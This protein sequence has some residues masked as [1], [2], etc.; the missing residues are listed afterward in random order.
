MKKIPTI[1]KQTTNL[2]RSPFSNDGYDNHIT[3]IDSIYDTSKKNVMNEID[4]FEEVL[5]DAT[6]NFNPHEISLNVLKKEEEVV[7]DLVGRITKEEDNIDYANFD[8][9]DKIQFKK[10][11]NE[12]NLALNVKDLEIKPAESFDKN[13]RRT[14]FRDKTS[15]SFYDY[16]KVNKTTANLKPKAKVFN[17]TLFLPTQK[18]HKSI[19]RKS[20][21]KEHPFKENSNFYKKSIENSPGLQ[22][23]QNLQKSTARGNKEEH[24]VTSSFELPRKKHDRQNLYK[25]PSSEVVTKRSNQRLKTHEKGRSTLLKFLDNPSKNHNKSVSNQTKNKSPGRNIIK[26]ATTRQNKETQERTMDFKSLRNKTFYNGVL[27]DKIKGQLFDDSS[28][29][30]KGIS[31]FNASSIVPDFSFTKGKKKRKFAKSQDKNNLFRSIRQKLR[32]IQNA[33]S[34]ED[35][36]MLKAATF[37]RP[38]RIRE[39]FKLKTPGKKDSK[40]MDTLKKERL[41]RRKDRLQLKSQQKLKKQVYEI[42]R[43]C[44]RYSVQSQKEYKEMSYQRL[45]EFLKMNEFDTTFGIVKELELSY[46]KPTAFTTGTNGQDLSALKNLYEYKVKEI[47]DNRKEANKIE[48]DY[49]TGVM[50]P[51]RLVAKIE[52]QIAIKKNV[53]TKLKVT[54]M[55]KKNQDKE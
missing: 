10:I 9:K 55:L 48:R 32:R 51:A 50:D 22:N 1:K 43:S 7:E 23:S 5:K 54:E 37:N 28:D 45:C 17:E 11:C 39:V 29:P 53:G 8:E 41:K 49:H 15:A 30:R 4:R 40:I 14:W 3:V 44:E 13:W 16:K 33:T 21:L 38:D 31:S 19:N 18:T 12:F 24:K 46:G 20:G 35:L 36:S 27:P 34:S 25:I 6:R 26:V 52:K 42:C 2:L 47:E